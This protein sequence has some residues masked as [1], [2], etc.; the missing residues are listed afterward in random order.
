[1]PRLRAF[2][3]NGY[4]LPLPAGHPF[5]MEKFP[6]AAAMVAGAVTLS[7][8][9]LVS[10]IDLE[11]VHGASYLDAVNRDSL[12]GPPAGLVP[13]HR[14]RLGLPSDPNLLHRSM[15]ETSGTVSASFA[16]LSDGIAANLAGG[17]HH[18]F[19]SQGLGFCVLNDVAVAVE[20]LRASGIH[21]PQIL[22]VD[23]DAHQGNANHAW[24]RQDPAVFTYSI[25]VGP[26]YPAMKEPGDR[27]VPLP[28]WVD[29]AA[30]LEALKSTL[31]AVFAQTEPDLVYWISG[32]DCHREDRFGRML[33]DDPAIAE[34][35][36]FVLG[37]CR[38]YAAPTVVLYGGGYNRRPGRTAFLHA[39]T[40][41]TAARMV[42]DFSRAT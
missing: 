20:T 30:Y 33:L 31:P 3:D 27:D 29:G 13:N 28:R 12:E 32:A 6:E 14:V 22:V 35:D 41:Q 9:N 19:P 39:Q 18:A 5:P 38:D 34:R 8:P 16:A 40:I 4:H 23:T 21:L 17:T 42:D 2:Y 11:R 37:L 1:M 10:R 15:L 36:R 26:N 24:F 7:P 25:H